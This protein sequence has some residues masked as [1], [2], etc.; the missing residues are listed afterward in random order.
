MCRR[1]VG[2]TSTWATYNQRSIWICLGIPNKPTKHFFFCSFCSLINFI[3]ANEWLLITVGSLTHDLQLWDTSQLFHTESWDRKISLG[4]DKQA[5]Q[6]SVLGK[7]E[8]ELLKESLTVTLIS[9][10]TNTTTAQN[11]AWRSL[12]KHWE[13]AQVSLYTVERDGEKNICVDMTVHKRWWYIRCISKKKQ[14]NPLG[15]FLAYIFL[16]RD[17]V[18]KK[19]HGFFRLSLLQHLNQGRRGLDT[20]HNW[21][22]SGRFTDGFLFFHN[23]RSETLQNPNTK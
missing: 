2:G 20:G 21:W 10:S 8:M 16:G 12:K 1:S 23:L 11:V 19:N 7:S 5:V 13:H 18:C 15:L 17:F 6:G 9:K 3:A 14:V 22:P 4:K